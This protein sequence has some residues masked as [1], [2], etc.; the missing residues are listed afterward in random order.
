MK[1]TITIIFAVILV[2]V[3]SGFIYDQTTNKG[4]DK[5]V[6]ISTSYGDIKVKLYKETPKHS[7]NFM[8]LAEE[9]YYDGLLFHRV[10]QNFMIQGGDP[11][12]RNAETG[13]MLGNGGPDYT[14]PSE[15]KYP[16]LF[17]KKGTLAAA[18]T[19]DQVNPTR[20]SSGSQFYI[21]QGQVYSDAQLDQFESKLG[22][23]FPQE[24]REAY[25]TQGGVPH[26]DGQ[27]TVFGEVVEGMD[28]IDKIAVV[29]TGNNDRPVEDVSMTIKPIK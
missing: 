15:I 7:S 22:Y 10:I 26:L 12:S 13:Q 24:V 9:G 1:N 19:G 11:D 6:L 21:V 27:Y 8:K 18:R 3:L 5:M 28:V 14:I 25:K 20:R 23:T 4:K 29:Q 17:H 2:T 16:E